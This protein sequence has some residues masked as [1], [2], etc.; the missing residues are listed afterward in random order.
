MTAWQ[1]TAGLKNLH[2]QVDQRFPHRDHASDGTI[3]DLAHQAETSGHN[4]DDTPGSKPAWNGDPDSTPEVR[5]WDMD[6]DLG[7]PGVTAQQVVDHVRRLPG[8]ANVIRYLIYNHRMYHVRDGFAP[9]VYS[10]PSPHEEHIH[11]EGAWSQAADNNTTFD[12]RLWEINMPTLDEIT[13]ACEQAISNVIIGAK[14]AAVDGNATGVSATDRQ[15]RDAV[16]KLGERN[17]DQITAAIAG[18]DEAVMAKL[19]DPKTPDAQVAEALVSLLGAR[20]DSVLALM[21]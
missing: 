7:E 10:G 17:R 15:V 5:A 14:N 13:G 19:T 8:V 9:T 4:P 11:F 21:K 18:V 3:G 1:L 16:W 12:Y 20:K 6:S 2:G